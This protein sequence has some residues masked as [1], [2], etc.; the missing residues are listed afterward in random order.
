MH[1]ENISYYALLTRVVNKLMPD[2][3]EQVI[4]AFA[5]EDDGYYL[6]VYHLGGF[7]KIITEGTFDQLQSNHIQ[8]EKFLYH[9]FNR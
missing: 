1:K 9:S 2:I 6:K 8:E 4:K 7:I 5:A 3:L